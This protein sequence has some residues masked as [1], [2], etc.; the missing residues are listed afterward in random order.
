MDA[1]SI[2]KEN[3]YIFFLLYFLFFKKTQL[4]DNRLKSDKLIPPLPKE[5]PEL[6]RG[7]KS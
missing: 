4:P 6:S 7:A 3:I 1:A 2:N 5:L